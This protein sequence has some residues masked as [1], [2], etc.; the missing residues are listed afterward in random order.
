MAN[1]QK[2]YSDIDFTFKP[3]P[4]TGDIALSYDDQSVIRSVRNLLLTNFYERPF[5]PNLG[6]NVN[7]IL[8]EMADALTS[9]ILDNE[10]RTVIKNY[11][12]RVTINQL[13]VTPSPDENS[14]TLY[15]SFF[16]GNNTKPTTV[17]LLLQRSR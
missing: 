9:N 14:F 16:I 11:E 8:F 13:I 4:V 2:I 7:T 3:L 1:L 12:P 15:L 5:Q 17:N 6:S 10:I